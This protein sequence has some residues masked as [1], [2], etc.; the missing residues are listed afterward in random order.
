MRHVASLLWI[1]ACQP[2]GGPPPGG[3][4]TP[5][6]STGAGTTSVGT[7]AGTIDACELPGDGNPSQTLHLVGEKGCDFAGDELLAVDL[8]GDG[9]DEVFVASTRFLA[10]NYYTYTP[11]TAVHGFSGPPEQTGIVG[12]GGDVL[13]ITG[14]GGADYWGIG[15]GYL[16]GAGR[17]V[18]G[19]RGQPDAV[20]H[21]FEVPEPL[22][23]ALTPADAVSTVVTEFGSPDW[24]LGAMRPFACATADGVE[25][26]CYPGTQSAAGDP[27]DFSGHIVLYEATATGPIPLLSAVSRVLGEPG[28]NARVATADAD[29]TGD[30]VA[31]LLIGAYKRNGT[32]AAAIVPA[33]AA[34]E[35]ALWPSAVATFDGVVGG[36]EFGL[37]VATGDFDGDGIV[38]V[39]IGAPI[40]SGAVYGFRG[41]HTG[42]RSA[43]GAD[44]VFSSSE[45]DHWFGRALALADFDGDGS[46]DLVIGAPRDPY[47]TTE[48][49]EVY[50]FASSA[51]GQR[52]HTTADAV[53]DAGRTGIDAFGLEVEAAQLDG[54][55]AME[56][57]VGAPRTSVEFYDQG[58]VYFFDEVLGP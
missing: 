36:A 26:F 35:H 9:I 39:F 57:V 52:E 41:P 48:P 5:S 8:G 24:G 38:D 33:P 25:R 6:G 22:Q 53:L 16:P 3:S 2:G 13:E 12:A 23:G 30:G 44:W 47:Y 29:L 28:D 56:L 45:P 27:F 43:A 55:P 49:G 42:A 15:L 19:G 4:G 40:G 51:P 7:P 32:G 50:V 21:L 10:S 37:T 34:G 54:D 14:T 20:A 46:T 17:L 58:A 11:L 1:V 31:D 18:V